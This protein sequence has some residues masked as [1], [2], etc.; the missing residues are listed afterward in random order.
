MEED[1]RKLSPQCK[2]KRATIKEKTEYSPIEVTEPLELVGMDLVDCEQIKAGNFVI[3]SLNKLVAG[4]PKRWDQLLQGT[5]FALRTKNQ[6]TTKFSPYYLMFVREARYPSEVPKEYE[7]EE[8]IPA[9]LKKELDPSPRA[10]PLTSTSTST[11][12]TMAPSTDCQA[13]GA[14][15]DV[16][17]LIRDIWAGGRKETLWAKYGPYKMTY[18]SSVGLVGNGAQVLRLT[19]G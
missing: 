15:S 9:K 6:L 14:S 13:R 4:E 12:K 16:E 1:I 3:R 5:M 7:P 8:R 18:P 10:D 2:S 17:T 11:S 19:N